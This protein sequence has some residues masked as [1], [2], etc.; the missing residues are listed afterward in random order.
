M[1]KAFGLTRRAGSAHG[2]QMSAVPA[3]LGVRAGEA[4]TRYEGGCRKDGT[5]TR[6]RGNPV[7]PRVPSRAAQA[8][9]MGTKL[10]AAASPG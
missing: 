8:G 4:V 5:R 2:S 9:K 10:A 1:P 7:D 6:F 3:D